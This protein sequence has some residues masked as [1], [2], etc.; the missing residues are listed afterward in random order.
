MGTLL[1]GVEITKPLLNSVTCHAYLGSNLI[2]KNFT[3]QW[4]DTNITSSSYYTFGMGQDGKLYV[5]S[6]SGIKRLELK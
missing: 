6:G 3:G 1:N 5:G 4:E 2:L